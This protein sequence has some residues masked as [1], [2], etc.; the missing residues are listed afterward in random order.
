MSTSVRV[1]R[2]NK[3]LA[4]KIYASRLSVRVSLGHISCRPIALVHRASC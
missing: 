4:T 3:I 1:D 2:I